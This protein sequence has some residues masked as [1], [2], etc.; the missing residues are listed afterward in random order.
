MLFSILFDD[1]IIDLFCFVRL[2]NRTIIE[3]DVKIE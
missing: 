1:T 2:R 3:T